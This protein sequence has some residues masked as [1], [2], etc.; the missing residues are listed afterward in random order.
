MISPAKYP[1]LFNLSGIEHSLV[2]EAKTVQENAE[3]D[4]DG[5]YN[6]IADAGE[7]LNPGPEEKPRKGRFSKASKCNQS[8]KQEERGRRLRKEL[9]CSKAQNNSLESMGNEGACCY[10]QRSMGPSDGRTDNVRRKPAAIRPEQW[11]S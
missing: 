3:G 7:T 10:F 11:C 9:H 5:A 6:N 1:E 2:K 8:F 4:Y